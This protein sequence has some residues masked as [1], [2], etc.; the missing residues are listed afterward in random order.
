MAEEYSLL[1][2]EQRPGK[3]KRPLDLK[4]YL[5]AR[6]RALL[7]GCRLRM[8]FLQVTDRRAE[9]RPEEEGTSSQ[10]RP[11]WLGS[12]VSPCWDFLPELG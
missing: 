10:C 9:S 6:G 4:V 7:S 1:V 8:K 5:G 12:A 2:L 11:V 3:I